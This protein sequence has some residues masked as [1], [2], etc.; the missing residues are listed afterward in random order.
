MALYYTDDG[1]IF[2]GCADGTLILYDSDHVKYETNPSESCSKGVSHG[3][4]ISIFYDKTTSLLVIGFNSGRIHIEKCTQGI[5]KSMSSKFQW[6]VCCGTLSESVTLHSLE[7]AFLKV[8]N[9]SSAGATHPLEIWCGTNTN[10]IEVW[11]LLFNS[12]VAWTTE[13]VE[14][15]R[16]IC[17][18]KLPR[19]EVDALQEVSLH[20]ELKSTLKLSEDSSKIVVLLQSSGRKA[21]CLVAIMDTASKDCLKWFNLSRSG[22]CNI[23]SFSIAYIKSFL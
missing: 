22:E 5:V 7:C 18:I 6:R 13:T 11:S 1:N 16:H 20:H 4:I 17:Y 9:E 21:T 2:V 10:T 23:Y 19:G 12:S 14:K 8:E 3:D 15:S